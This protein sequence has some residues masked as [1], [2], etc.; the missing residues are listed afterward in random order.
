MHE[1]KSLG[2]FAEFLVRSVEHRAELAGLEL[3]EA[4]DTVAGSAVLFL[5]AS[6]FLLLAAMAFTALIAAAFWNTAFR[7]PSLAGIGVIYGLAGYGLFVRARTRIEG[8][9]I[10]PQTGDQLKRDV[11]CIAEIFRNP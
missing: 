6:G 5:A 10:F 9:R 7:L 4:R 1:P 8:C 2:E 11:S 3:A